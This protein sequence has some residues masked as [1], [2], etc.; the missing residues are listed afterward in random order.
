MLKRGWWL[1]R[2]LMFIICY[3]WAMYTSKSE[4]SFRHLSVC[5]LSLFFKLPRITELLYTLSDQNPSVWNFLSPELEHVTY[6]CHH[7]SSRLFSPYLR[8]RGFSRSSIRGWKRRVGNYQKLQS[9]LF[10]TVQSLTLSWVSCRGLQDKYCHKSEPHRKY[11]EWGE[12]DNAGNRYFA[13][14]SGRAGYGPSPA[15]IVVSNPTGGTDVC[16]LW[17]LCVASAT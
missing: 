14:P 10:L 2:I 17:V 12:K 16:L 7:N 11:V 8:S 5:Y 6:I 9:D 13:D 3:P 15:E 4:P 1:H